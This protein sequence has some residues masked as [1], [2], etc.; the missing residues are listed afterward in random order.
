MCSM[1][2]IL[3]NSKLMNNNN[4]INNINNINNPLLNKN[5]QILSQINPQYLYN[6]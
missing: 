6:L 4:I 5:I 1:N 2:M 3:N